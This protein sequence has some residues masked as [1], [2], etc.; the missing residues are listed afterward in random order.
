MAIRFIAAQKSGLPACGTAAS[1]PEYHLV[2]SAQTDSRAAALAAGH[3]LAWL[4]PTDAEWAGEIP[5]QILEEVIPGRMWRTRAWFRTEGTHLRSSGNGTLLRTETGDLAFLNAVALSDAVA[6]LIGE[7]GEVRWLTTGSKAHSAYVPGLV[8]RFPRARNL[9]VAAHA[10]HPASRH[11]KFD[12]PWITIPWITIPWITIPWITM[13][14][15][16]RSLGLRSL[17]S[18]SLGS[19][20]PLD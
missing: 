9:G 15:G 4:C 16:S 7:L 13:T 20:S 12:G 14:L 1:F 18:R 8:A 17:G 19:R 6:A 3:P 11:L 10:T 2:F 5:E